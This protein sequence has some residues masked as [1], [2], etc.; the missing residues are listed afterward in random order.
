MEF[1][2]AQEWNLSVAKSGS[3]KFPFYW[4]E[5]ETLSYKL[6]HHP[7]KVASEDS[8]AESESFC[9]T[10]TNPSTIL[11]VETSSYPS[12]LSPRYALT[13]V[14]SHPCA[15][16]PMCALTQ[17]RSHPGT[18]SPRYTLTQVRS[19]PD[20]LSPRHALTQTRSHPGTLP[21]RYKK[22]GLKTSTANL[23]IWTS[24]LCGKY[25][26]LIGHILA[27]VS[28]I[29]ELFIW[30]TNS[31]SHNVIAFNKLPLIMDVYICCY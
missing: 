31:K 19:H 2:V 1:S 4:H 5:H 10:N 17:V 14:R 6:A 18:L 12:T 23:R 11:L 20:T 8:L 27:R 15:L 13:Q 22:W 16:S 29:P 9:G 3:F 28:G 24:C 7:E 25:S 26:H 21:P 30:D